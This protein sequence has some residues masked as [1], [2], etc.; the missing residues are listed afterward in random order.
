M[1]KE[2]KVRPAFRTYPLEVYEQFFSKERWEEIQRDITHWAN[3]ELKSGKILKG[4]I[5]N[6]K[7]GICFLSENFENSANHQKEYF[8]KHA[9]ENILTD[10]EYDKCAGYTWQV[11]ADKRE[12]RIF[13]A[14]KKVTESEYGGDPV[15]HGDDFYV[16][17]GDFRDRW[18]D[19]FD[20][21]E[22]PLPKYVYGSTEEYT[23][24]ENDIDEMVQRHFENNIG[25][26]EDWEPNIPDVPEYLQQAW[27][28]FVQENA[29]KYYEIDHKTV[30]ILDKN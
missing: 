26:F 19:D 16:D 1:N 13:E 5:S 30:V 25:D 18:E 10:E 29:E 14:A 28:R 11:D 20:P 7:A 17:T 12:Q 4:V 6:P 21:E 8:M 27:N 22:D 9:F 24:K 15:F 2:K 3:P 23:L